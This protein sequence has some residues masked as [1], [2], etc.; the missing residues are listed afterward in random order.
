MNVIWMHYTNHVTYQCQLSLTVNHKSSPVASWDSKMSNIYFRISP[1]VLWI[2]TSFVTRY[3][4]SDAA[5]VCQRCIVIHSFDPDHVMYVNYND[6][7]HDV[8]SD[9]LFIGFRTRVLSL[10]PS[11]HCLRANRCAVC[12]VKTLL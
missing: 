5:L 3:A 8:C 4:I 12:A 6:E 1:E 7:Q 10:L 11:S 2:Q 9:L